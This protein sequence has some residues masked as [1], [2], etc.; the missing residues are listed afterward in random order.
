MT[1][2]S[3][4]LL[5]A[6]ALGAFFLPLL[7]QA[8]VPPRQPGAAE[9]ERAVE[10]LGVVGNVL[11]IAAH[12]D[13]E[14]TRLLAYLANEKLVRTTYLSLTRGDGGQ[15]LIG[16]EQGSLLGLI[17]T[18]ELLA[19]RR[20]DGAEQM[21][22]RARDF[23]YSKTPEETLRIWNK[24]EVLAD[25]VWAI[26]RF[27]PDLIIT[28]FPT[29]GVE[30]HGH[31]LSSAILAGEAFQAAADPNFHPEQVKLVGTWKAKRLLW[32]AWSPNRL[33]PGVRPGAGEVPPGELRMDIG[34]YNPYLGVSYGELAADS[35]S[36][37]KSQGFGVPRSRGPQM[38][39]FQPLAGEAAQRS[40]FDGL[41]L[42][43]GRVPGAVHLAEL[44]RRAR[45]E[46]KTGTPAS[47]VPILVEAH[48]ELER[49]ADNPWK[50]AKLREIEAVIAGCA[51]LFTEVSAADSSV[52]P[53]QQLTVT[54]SALNRVGPAMKLREIRLLGGAGGA[55]ASNGLVG[56][57]HGQG[58]GQGQGITV[59]VDRAL[60]PGEP[61]QVEQ[62]VTVPA[63]ME[64]SNPYWL[65]E[66][67]EPGMFRVRDPM[68]IGLPENPPALS[69]EFVL[70]IGKLTLRVTRPV[71]YK[72]TD[73]VA[74]ER[75]RAVEVTPAVML[76]PGAPVLM[77]PGG[78]GAQGRELR[79]LL[80]AGMAG[81]QGTLRLELPAGWRAEPA[82]QPFALKDKGAEEEFRFRIQAPTLVAGAAPIEG[83]A[84]AVAEVEGQRIDRG[85][86]RIE[87]PHIPIQTLFPPAEVRLVRF[88]LKKQKTHIGYVAGA[89]D[90][91]AQSLR[92]VG[93]EVTLL[94]NAALADK[95]L[96]RYEAV[97]M[98]VRAYNTN[99]RLPYLR[100]KLMDYV[101]A[102]GTLLVQ[103]NT[104]ERGDKKGPDIGPYPF[105]ISHDRVTDETAEVALEMPQHPVLHAPNAITAADFRGW[106]QERGLY[107]A[108]SWDTHYETPLSMHDPG[109]TPKKGNLLIA[110]HGKGAFIYTGLSF[111]RQLPAGVP[112]AYRL[113]ANLIAYGK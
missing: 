81:V 94:D 71:I 55:V 40:I 66:A 57:G 91:V 51:G 24:D 74:G 97:V 43:W 12:P 113:F 75:Y 9:L 92:Q 110:R 64:Y 68:L 90:D 62:M 85:V 25:M 48:A 18:Q 44:L 73:P 78:E 17:R 49:L 86:V 53:G 99:R 35:R 102:G 111:F 63:K 101:A 107:F 52:V 108:D 36:M 100:K 33:A 8:S 104:T 5:A 42:T 19:A 6:S 82:A 88:D 76:N 1:L 72:W 65:A 58:Q 20:I 70:E 14:N 34:V 59:A 93:Y 3:T 15:N 13:D 11:Y 77:F 28:R 32:N 21:F 83:V 96:D 56:A 29:G 31:H 60:A 80:K 2:P 109:E 103:Y 4:F 23:G 98:G 41:D 61:F 79:V 26:R 47:V 87:Y 10:R 27:K 38:E 39:G 16:P 95:P 89:G 45:A 30:T 7:S 69:A 105:S 22:T 67:P 46:F 50:E 84:R 112:G 37:H 54:A 106:V